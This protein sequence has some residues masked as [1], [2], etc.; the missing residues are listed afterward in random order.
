MKKD[1]GIKANEDFESFSQ[2]G[3]MRGFSVFNSEGNTEYKAEVE[4][5]VY[6]L[7]R[8]LYPVA[9]STMPPIPVATKAVEKPKKVEKSKRAFP[10]VLILIFN[11]VILAIIAIA[12]F[13]IGKIGSYIAPFY[14]KGGDTV[15]SVSLLDGLF[16]QLG[17]DMAKIDY[18]V[19]ADAASKI[20]LI[21]F[22]VTGAL[23]A[24]FALWQVIASIV[25]LAGQKKIRFG[26]RAF[27]TLLF[28]LGALL[29]L[30]ALK[31]QLGFGDLCCLILPEGAGDYG[32]PCLE[33][34]YVLYGGYGLYALI[35]LPIL[36]MICS[37]CVYK[38]K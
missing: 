26:W 11:L 8:E 36:T 25:C 18:T 6:E 15:V 3:T 14:K 1:S 17:L 30:I 29:S 37:S 38:K 27:L 2:N 28:L 32:L 7:R 10:A 34:G 13:D 24:V 9:E 21:A 35:V 23:V 16:A 5:M 31:A 22:A 33:E 19:H 20:A 4:R 12:C